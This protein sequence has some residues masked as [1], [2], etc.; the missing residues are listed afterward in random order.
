MAAVTIC[1][2]FADP[3]VKFVTVSIVSP[4]ICHEVMGLDAM[5]LVFWMLSFK[6]QLSLYHQ[7]ASISLL[8]FSIRG[9]TEWKP[10]S[11]K[12]NQT[13]HMEHSLV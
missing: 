13:D 1:N 9:Q 5:I 11:Q 4:F 3:K 6:P 8:C 12:T 7:E 10:Q 2:D